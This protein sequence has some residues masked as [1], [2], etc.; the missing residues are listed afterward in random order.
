[1]DLTLTLVAIAI[2]V[3]IFVI[4]AYKYKKT[5]KEK[6][7]ERLPY[8][9]KSFFF[10]KSEREFYR[11]LIASLDS[12]RFAIFPKVRLGDFIDSIDSGRDRASSWGKIRSRHVDFL[13]WC[14]ESNKVVLAIEIDGNS[15][16]RE[17]VKDVDAFKDHL[18][19][20]IELELVRVT[21][22]TNFANEIE[23]IKQKL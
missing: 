2:L 18:F 10:T 3:I 17:R 14:V 4:A 21:V 20:S 11:L 23:Q 5:L 8:R 1:M 9:L 19:R 16:R 12:R 6:V 22:G 13:I 15:H 7:E